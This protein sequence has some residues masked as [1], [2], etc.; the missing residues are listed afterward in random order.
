MN[1]A[2][3]CLLILIQLSLVA[4][5]Q[6]N[7]PRRHIVKA[8]PIRALRPLVKLRRHPVRTGNYRKDR[9]KQELIQ[10]DSLGFKPGG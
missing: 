10:S 3:I 1:K 6:R 4:G 7:I 9:V 5:A 2:L 8:K